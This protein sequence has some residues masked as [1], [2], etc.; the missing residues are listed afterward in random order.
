MDA[1][2]S[3]TLFF[4]DRDLP[5]EKSRDHG[6][7]RR[8]AQNMQHIVSALIM[9]SYH[10]SDPSLVATIVVVIANMVLS[11][12]CAPVERRRKDFSWVKLRVFSDMQ[13][14]EYSRAETVVGGT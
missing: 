8:I 11:N 2:L 1:T 5:P 12:S 3:K 14:R 9:C 13:C 7:E 10:P 6:S 4:D